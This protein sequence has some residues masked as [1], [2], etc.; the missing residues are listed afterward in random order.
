LLDALPSFEAFA[1][2]AS[3]IDLNPV[4]AVGEDE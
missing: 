1:V 2:A 4:A 3:V